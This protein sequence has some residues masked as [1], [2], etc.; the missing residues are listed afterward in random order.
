MLTARRITMRKA[1][2]FLDP[3]YM[4]Y[5]RVVMIACIIPQSGQDHWSIVVNDSPPSKKAVTKFVQSRALTTI[6]PKILTKLISDHHHRIKHSKQTHT[7]CSRYVEA[8]TMFNISL[9][10]TYMYAVNRTEM[11]DTGKNTHC[12][13]LRDCWKGGY[14]LLVRKHQRT[15]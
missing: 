13:C 12:I 1:S 14:M 3:W 2:I 15:A 10:P 4:A 9:T 11:R 8:S 7:C 6:V 5:S